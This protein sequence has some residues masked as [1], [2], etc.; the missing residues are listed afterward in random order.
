D[1]GTKDYLSP[2]TLALPKIV[3]D[4]AELDIIF[5][6]HPEQQ[7]N[8]QTLK[9]EVNNRIALADEIIATY[10]THGQEA[11]FALVR[12][13]VG[14]KEMD[15]IRHLINEMISTERF[16]LQNRRNI[17]DEALQSTFYI[18]GA[19][20]AACFVIMGFV[21][22]QIARENRLRGQTE[23]T[24]KHA[25][26]EMQTLS[27]ENR[28]ISHMA[29]YLQS[30]QTPD[31]AYKILEDLMP[32]L[33][34][35]SSGRISTFNNSRNLI[36]STLTW[37]GNADR[38]AGEFMPQ[39][40]W[41]LR[42]GQPH[43]YRRGGTE[44]ICT[45]IS[46]SSA[47]SLCLPMQAHGETIGLLHMASDDE[48]APLHA[49]RPQRLA[50]RI[51]EQASL[52][53]SNLK[54]QN[55]LLVQSTHDPLTRLFNRRYLETTLEREISRAKRSGQ[56]LCVM[57]LDIDHFKKF[58]DTRG[59]DAGD[60]LLVHF[61]KLLQAKTRK[62]DIVCRY[63]GEEFVVVLPGASPDIGLMLAEKLCAATREMDVMFNGVSLGMITVSIGIASYPQHGESQE[64][65]ISRADAALYMAKHG[66]RNQALLAA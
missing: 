24:L 62:E 7:K 36:E 55:K 16:R 2:Y 13:G 14:K 23:D 21:F 49:E 5:T 48:T 50:K 43:I 10:D 58:N 46:E 38:N 60:A 32:A 56:P 27:D 63:G 25:L 53:I 17:T 41:A 30:C 45:H 3:S 1:T 61:A 51:S 64:D 29:E 37:G 12:K 19:G 15:E 39:E 11:A 18:S 59:H 47:S 4:F 22:Y 57:V 42:R 44:P 52:A 54:L 65:L 40:C 20:L 31:E 34:P 26:S 35:A 9:K 28:N 8:L 33:F 66:G 6:N